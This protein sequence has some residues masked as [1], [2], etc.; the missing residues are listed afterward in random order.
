MKQLLIRTITGAIFVALMIWA[1]LSAKMVLFNVFLIFTCIAL[2]EYVKMLNAKDINISWAFYIVALALYFFIAYDP[3]FNYVGEIGILVI[4]LASSMIL[5]IV[6]LFRNSYNAFDVI[7]YEVLGLL[8]IV[9][10]MA[11]INRIPVMFAHGN[12]ILLLYFIIIWMSDT[13]AYCVGSLIGK[14]KLFERVSPK[15]TW[16]GSI[17]SLILTMLIAF[18]I[19]KIFPSVSLTSW[20][21][22]SMALIVFVSGTIGDLMESLLKRNFE[23]KDSGGILPGHGGILDRFDSTL[24][25]IPCVII[26][27][28]IIL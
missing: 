3:L 9:L 26:Y 15:K 1:T 28:I 14:H 22:L 16:E 4:V 19:P 20:Q 24:L 11:L 8:W 10:P 17:G 12:V 7:A 23:V 18:F 21:M 5:M 27:L 25:S 13:F 2:Y 6:D